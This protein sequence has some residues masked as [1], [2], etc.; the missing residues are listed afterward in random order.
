MTAPKKPGAAAKR[1]AP[2]KAAKAP[3]KAR[4][5]TKAQAASAKKKRAAAA[6]AKSAKLSAAGKKGGRPKKHRYEELF[7]AIQDPRTIEDPLDLLPWVLSVQ[8]IA[9][10]ETLLGRGNR[11]I[12]AE[13][14]AAA[15]VI[16]ALIPIERL[17][18]AE[19][20]VLAESRQ[21]N[22]KLSKPRGGTLSPAPKDSKPIR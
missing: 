6:K 1:A 10:N 5:R 17:R 11:E 19:R 8:A 3:A 13:I 22:R 2:K 4:G 7:A 16:R 20:N 12:N 18:Q 21:L 14:R 15:R 9:I